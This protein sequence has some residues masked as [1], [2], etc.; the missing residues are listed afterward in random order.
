SLPKNKI[1]V[2]ATTTDHL[3]FIGS[4]KG[5]ACQSIALLKKRTQPI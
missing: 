4:E 5:W 1:S 2:K 3:G